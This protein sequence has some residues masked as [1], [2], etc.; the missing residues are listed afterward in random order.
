MAE[1]GWEKQN[2]DDVRNDVKTARKMKWRLVR[3]V[4][5]LSQRVKRGK[6]EMTQNY[7]GE[8]PTRTP[9]AYTP[10]SPKRLQTTVNS[11]YASVKM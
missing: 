8:K 3:N 6:H 7:K 2:D 11:N 10:L 5:K 9:S 4:S 1:I